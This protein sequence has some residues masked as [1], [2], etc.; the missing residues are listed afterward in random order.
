MP[1]AILITT[2]PADCSFIVRRTQAPEC[3]PPFPINVPNVQQ[4][5]ESVKE[6]LEKEA[7]PAPAAAAAPAPAAPAP[8]PAADK[9]TF[10]VTLKNP[11][12]DQVVE[13]DPA[14]DMYLLDYLDE[15]DNAD[16]FAELPYACRAGSCSACAGKVVSGTVDA[17]GCG[18]LDE[19]Q[20]AAGWI[21]TCT[22]K[23]TSDV[24]IE[25]HQEDNLY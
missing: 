12:G 25:T 23:P 3:F 10:T 21:L 11:D 6:I 20:K 2:L 22:A 24:V 16:D 15:L 8:A 1:S 4:A 9:S 7:A 13:Y 14:S 17:S 5:A 18:F 19:E